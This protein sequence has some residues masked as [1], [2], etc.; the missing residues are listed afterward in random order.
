MNEKKRTY[1]NTCIPNKM[2]II[3]HT[4]LMN[5]HLTEWRSIDSL[6]YTRAHNDIRT[7]Q[8]RTYILLRRIHTVYCHKTNEIQ[9]YRCHDGDL[10]T[11]EMG[12]ERE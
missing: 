8:N 2:V 7:E 1:D 4:Q 6:V 9:M 12:I 5:T 3:S 10:K 11:T